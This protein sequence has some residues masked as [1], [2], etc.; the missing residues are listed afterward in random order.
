MKAKHKGAVANF[1]LRQP[2]GLVTVGFSFN[3]ILAYS[4]PKTRTLGSS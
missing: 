3:S 2:L 4:L 1:Y